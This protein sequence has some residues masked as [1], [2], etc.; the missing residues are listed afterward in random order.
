MTVSSLDTIAP[1]INITSPAATATYRRG[2]MLVVRFACSDSGSGV[3]SCTAT[4]TRA[5]SSTRTVT[6]GQSVQLQ[7][8]SY[9]FKVSARDRAGNTAAKTMNFTVR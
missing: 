4:L 6:S 8:G 1:T 7:K 3:A 2:Q 9:T 5:G